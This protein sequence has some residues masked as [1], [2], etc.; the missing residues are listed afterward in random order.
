VSPRDLSK[1]ALSEP[2]RS[3][4]LAALARL[5]GP[6]VLARAG[7]TVLNVTNLVMIGHAGPAELARQRI[8]FSLTNTLQMIEFGLLT[9]TLM[10]VAVGF[11]RE[12]FVEGTATRYLF[13]QLAA[14]EH[15]Q[16]KLL[17]SVSCGRVL[18]KSSPLRNCGLVLGVGA[19]R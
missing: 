19:S 15:R 3:S 16:Q 4:Q 8:A 17:Q 18:R 12:D 1:A 14:S 13:R 7:N 6:V 2:S 9:G 10:A 5:A 11:G